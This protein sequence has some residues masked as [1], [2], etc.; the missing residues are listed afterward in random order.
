[1]PPGY[2]QIV[3]SPVPRLNAKGVED[4]PKIYCMYEYIYIVYNN[5]GSYLLFGLGSKG[6]GQVRS[7]AGERCAS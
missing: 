2:A 3:D 5:L 7:P 6:S 4:L 1:M